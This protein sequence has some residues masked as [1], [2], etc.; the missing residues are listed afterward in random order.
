M[1]EFTADD[2][3]YMSRAINLAWRGRYTTQP[4]PRVGCVLVKNGS[5]VGEGWHERAGEAHAEIH[6]LAM[7][8]DAARGATAYVTLEP[9]CHHGRTPPCSDALIQAGVIKVIA[10][11]QDPNEKVAGKGLQQLQQADIETASG[12]LADEAYDLNPGFIKRMKTGR[13]FVRC[14][15]AMSLDGRTAMASGES[16]W[17]TSEAARRDVQHWRAQADCI[18]TGIG[19]V[20]QD[21]PRMNVRL[22]EV[23][24]QPL[25]AIVDSRFRITADRQ[26]LQQAD[27]S[28]IFTC[29]ENVQVE[30]AETVSIKE[31]DGRVDLHAVL[32][33]LGQRDINEVHLESGATLSGAMLRAGLVD[34]LVIYMAPVLM[35][36]EARGLF[37][38]PGLQQMTDKIKLDIF[39]Q[40]SVGQDW[41]LRA[42]IQHC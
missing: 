23:E 22:P 15:M 29:A 11:M 26:I 19:T 28:V 25:R 27:R 5:I 42:R 6:A 37:H 38:V 1:S 39:E 14:K 36:D 2:Y 40:R 3:R 20:M 34:E 16:N 10:A 32:D 8:G 12:L 9:C 4:N 21:D 35:G 41:R 33:E 18:L 17:I 24:R 13:P 7:A 31:T 30:N